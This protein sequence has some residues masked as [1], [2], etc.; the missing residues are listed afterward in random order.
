MTAEERERVGMTDDL[1]RI[2]CGI[3][4]TEDLIADFAQALEAASVPAA[5]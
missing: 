4:G 1:V 3:E 2:C 5:A